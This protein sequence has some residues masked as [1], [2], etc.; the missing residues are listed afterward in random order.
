MFSESLNLD[1][2]HFST[3]RDDA[4]FHLF[5]AIFKLSLSLLQTVRPQRNR[6]LAQKLVQ[7][8]L[9]GDEVLQSLD[10]FL[11][12]D[13]SRARRQLLGSFQLLTVGFLLFSLFLIL[14]EVVGD[15][16]EVFVNILLG[17]WVHLKLVVFKIIF[18]NIDDHFFVS[19]GLKAGIALLLLVEVG[20][21]L[22]GQ[23]LLGVLA[24]KGDRFAL[25]TSGSE[26]LAP[27]GSGRTLDL[28][29]DVAVLLWD[30]SLSYIE[31]SRKNIQT[32]LVADLQS[33]PDVG[34][35]RHTA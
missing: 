5:E 25:F 1:V 2:D 22:G 35:Y 30:V 17:G 7:F 19:G 12:A 21:S 15:L 14:L 34:T 8:F 9:G 11:L 33:P 32:Y 26:R 16:A 13:L 3:E 31:I 6:H 29:L 28:R 18:V 24:A 20:E 4:L 23:R 27:S 10:P